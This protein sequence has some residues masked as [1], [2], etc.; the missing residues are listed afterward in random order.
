MRLLVNCQLR[1]RGAKDKFLF[2]F[3]NFFIKNRPEDLSENYKNIAD[4]Y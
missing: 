2:V 1:E 3:T 4:E